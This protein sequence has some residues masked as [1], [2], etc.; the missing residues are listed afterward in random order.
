MIEGYSV[1]NFKNIA[2]LPQYGEYVEFDRLNVLIG[3]NGSGKSSLLQ[4]MDFLKAFFRTSVELYLQERE[5]NYRDLPNLR[6][7][8]KE[9]GW[10][11]KARLAPDENGEGGG[12]YVYQVSLQPKRYLGIGAECL[13]YQKNDIS[14]PET[15]IERH[16]RK[17]SYFDRILGRRVDI[18]FPR[19][20][21]SLASTWD[22]DSTSDRKR[23]PEALRFRRWVESFRYYLLW[24]PKVLRVPVRGKHDELGTSGEHLA[25]V[26]GKM[27]DKHPDEYK[28]LIDR[29]KNIFPNMSNLSVFG[30]GWGWRFIQL[31]ERGNLKD[32]VFNSQHVSDG[33]LRMIAIVSL[34]YLDKVPS[35]LMLEEPENGMHPQLVR[36]VVQILREITHRKSPNQCQVFFSTHSPYILDEFLDHPSEVYCLDRIS[37]QSGTTIA[38]LGDNKEL[39]EMQKKMEYSLGEA[40]FNGL[41]GPAKKIR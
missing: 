35:V 22:W 27:R 36:S 18:Q 34:L 30:K 29:L 17:C 19:L 31:H 7:T 10:K 24:D 12:I 16:G 26:I 25:S 20:P 23:H 33:I 28:R 9:L 40:W 15:L 2:K 4:S 11:I 14:T 39:V 38:R 41:F 6:N 37:P 5:W 32:V 8:G 13:T 1:Q 21:A 3:P